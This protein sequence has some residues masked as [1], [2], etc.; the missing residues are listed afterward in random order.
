MHE[1]RE[2]PEHG[3]NNP[4]H[5]RTRHDHAI[6]LVIGR[7]IKTKNKEGQKTLLQFS[8]P[9]PAPASVPLVAKRTNSKVHRQLPKKL[10]F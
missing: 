6:N 4:E 1:H 9:G 3:A 10:H 7:L 8:G 2:H 5:P